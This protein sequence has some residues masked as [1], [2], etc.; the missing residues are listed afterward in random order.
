MFGCSL[1]YHPSPPPH[2]IDPVVGRS[3]SIA[4]CLGRIEVFK[5]RSFPF[6]F[7]SCARPSLHTFRASEPPSSLTRPCMVLVLSLL[8]LLFI[9]SGMG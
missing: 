9:P 4:L 7:P 3:L 2:P 8:C 1:A 6:T 5:A